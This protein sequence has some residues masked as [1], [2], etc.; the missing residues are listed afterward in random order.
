MA[1]GRTMAAC[2]DKSEMG[3]FL[4]F[5]GSRQV[6]RLSGTPGTGCALPWPHATHSTR[7][8]RRPLLSPHQS[9]QQDHHLITV[10]RYVERNALRAGLVTR[11]RLCQRAAGFDRSRIDPNLHSTPASIRRS[12][13]GRASSA[14]PRVAAV[15]CATRKTAT[16][17]RRVEM[18][19]VPIS[20]LTARPQ[21][22][23]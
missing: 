3:T 15:P 19:N 6:R 14:R 13:L 8:R 16:Q 11:A 7:Y 20:G 10:I 17:A 12:E 22:Q 18:R 5:T 2:S 21:N 4:I 1:Q 9:R 23:L